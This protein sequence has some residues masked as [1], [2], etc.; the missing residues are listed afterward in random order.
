M[1]D[2]ISSSPVVA[3]LASTWPSGLMIALPPISSTPSS[4]PALAT[5]TTKQRLA[6]APARMQSSFRS[7]ASAEIGV[8]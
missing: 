8:L 5:P 7:S 1:R 6:Y 4:T 3:A 2:T